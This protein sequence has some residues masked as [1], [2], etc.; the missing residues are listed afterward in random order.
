MK[1]ICIIIRF[2]LTLFF[3]VEI[4][5]AYSQSNH[6]YISLNKYQTKLGLNITRYK[7]TKQ[8]IYFINH[9]PSISSNLQLMAPAAFTSNSFQIDGFA[10][11]FGNIIQ[12]N[13]NNS[14]NGFC[15]IKN[16]K[17]QIIKLE[18]LTA[19]F[20]EDIIKSKSSIFQQNLLI[21]NKAAVSF[22]LFEN[23]KDYWRALALFIDHFELIENYSVCTIKAFQLG[24]L[25]IGVIDAIYL[26][27][28]SLSEGGYLNSNNQ[29]V[30]IGH[31]FGNTIHQ[32]NW[33]VF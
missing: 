21:Q 8:K 13:L 3:L 30:R 29:K 1:F 5:E 18:N 12:S 10:V 4:A 16:G 7:S 25:D 11:C 2:L 32:T 28:G 14:L 22:P 27:M 24:L 6:Y 17:P 20:K 33:I 15:Y 31:E 9:R 19:K 23:K 26:D